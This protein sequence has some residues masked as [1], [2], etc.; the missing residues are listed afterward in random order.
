[1]AAF[2]TLDQVKDNLGICDS[3]DDTR[4][5]AILDW[6]LKDIEGRIWD[7]QLWEKTEKIDKKMRMLKEGV[8]PFSI[9]PVVSITEIDATDF[10]TKVEWVDYQ[11]NDNWTAEVKDLSS[12]IETD[13]A[14][15]KIIYQAGY[16]K[17][18][19][20]YVDIVSSLVWLEFSK[21]M[22]KDVTEETTGPRTVKFSDPGRFSWGPDDLKRAQ[23]KRLRKFIP[24]HLRVY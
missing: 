24:V 5:W 7:I 15:F 6:V 19:A 23:Y 2:V 11:I 17:A 18:P 3:S 13:F 10:S 12:Y 9:G 14:K 21:D 16:A 8:L 1:M 20:D 22:W 4:L